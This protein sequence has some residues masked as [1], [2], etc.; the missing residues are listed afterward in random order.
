MRTSVCNNCSVSDVCVKCRLIIYR[1]FIWRV[2][3][4]VPRSFPFRS[5]SS[6]STPSSSEDPQTQNAVMRR[7]V[8]KLCVTV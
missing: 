2:W 8:V 5:R 4:G 3:W 6:S 1:G 7:F